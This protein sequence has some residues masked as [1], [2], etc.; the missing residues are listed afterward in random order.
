M[1]EPV[2][3][4]FA[5]ARK[6]AA[7]QEAANAQGATDAIQ[8]RMAAQG[9]GP[10]GAQIKLEAQARDQSA[11]RL[12]S[13]NE[14]IDA[15]EQAENR[16]VA[17]IKEGRDFARGEREASQQ[18][19]H[20]E[21]LG[22]QEFARGERMGGQE[23]AALQAE[24]QRKYQTGE[25]LSSQEYA[26]LEAGK[27]RE[28]AR[29]ERLGSQDFAASESKLG[30]DQQADQFNKNYLLQDKQ[31]DWDRQF[32]KMAFDQEQQNFMQQMF[33]QNDQFQ[34]SKYVDQKNLDLAARI[35]RANEAEDPGLLGMGGF[36]GTGL[37]GKGGLLGTGIGGKSRPKFLK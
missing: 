18:F 1:A 20:G 17:E 28:F 37:G 9:G 11:Q 23:F 19:A 8:R 27:Q 29:G 26:A 5:L 12:A 3:D 2:Q 21:R 4:Q 34:W 6:R 31:M 22:G 15:A 13:A 32:K 16:R 10:S 24:A 33:A 7:T 14:G 30:R 36:L 25:R 35:Q